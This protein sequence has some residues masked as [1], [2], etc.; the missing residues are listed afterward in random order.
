MKLIVNMISI[1]FY[2]LLIDNVVPRRHDRATC[3]EDGENTYE[4]AMW[5]LI[6]S[7]TTL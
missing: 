5:A 6:K 4:V 7:E 2:C 3:S 1:V